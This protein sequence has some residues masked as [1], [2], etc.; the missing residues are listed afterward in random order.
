MNWL[1]V[2][3]PLLLAALVLGVIYGCEAWVRMRDAKALRIRDA[4]LNRYSMGAFKGVTKD[5][6]LL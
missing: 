2:L 5:W 1:I 3:S 6:W 4:R